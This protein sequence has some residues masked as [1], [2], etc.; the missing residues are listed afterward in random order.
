M[1]KLTKAILACLV[2]SSAGA[3][4]YYYQVEST[5]QEMVYT[6]DIVRKGNIENVVLTNGVLYPNKLVNVGAQVSG[7]IE[8]IAVE[9]GQEVQ[10]GELIGQID[11]LTQQNELKEAIASLNSIE[12]QIRAKQAMIKQSTS[13]FERQTLM[14]KN[15]ASSQADYD[16]SEAELAIYKAE[17]DQLYAEKQKAEINV[18]TAHLNL[19]YTTI[20]SPINGTVVY[21]SVE[22]GQTVNTNQS[23]PTIVEIAE[24]DTMV[25]RAQISEADVIHATEGQQAYFS[26]L[27]A[28]KKQFR[29]VLRS[30]EPGPTLMTGDDS[31]LE[32]GDNDAIYYNARFE[33]QNPDHLLRIGMTAQVSIILDRAEGA[34][35]IPAQVLKQVGNNSFQ[36]PVLNNGKMEFRSIQVGINNKI[37]AE[38]LSGLQEGDEVV[39]G[40]SSSVA[41]SSMPTRGRGQGPMGL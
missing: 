2:I 23:T 16:N 7:K 26:I 20:D 28:P 3:G 32:I 37:Y 41:S 34:L 8:Q 10:Q 21:V 35:M 5:Q 39:I 17:L 19:S 15:R 36:V 18:D 40:R 22:E 11:N 6:T 1:K 27:G 14:L 12:A 4:A 29:G 30:I 31:N 13:S 25:V 33:V 9:L 38:V 24:L